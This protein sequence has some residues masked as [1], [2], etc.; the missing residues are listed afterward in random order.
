MRKK[1]FTRGEKI[2]D[3]GE[4][5]RLIVGG[6]YI[7]MN[8]KPMHPGWMMGMQLGT[9]IRMTRGGMLYEAIRNADI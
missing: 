7:F 2:E 9:V 3:Y 4:A 8:H 1:K 5:V 6:N